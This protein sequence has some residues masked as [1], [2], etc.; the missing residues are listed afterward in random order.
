[1]KELKNHGIS[2]D[3]VQVGNEM[4]SGILLP[5]GSTNDFSKLTALLNK[6]YD[7]VKS[8]SPPPRSSAIWHTA[9]TTA[10]SDGGLINSLKTEEKPT[11]S[12]FRS[13][14]IGKVS[15]TGSSPANY[16]LI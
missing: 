14:P 8:V 7:A 4:N 5:D 1:M 12:A 6:G 13:I 15:R 2:P 3:W 16:P 9:R 10:Y 11:S